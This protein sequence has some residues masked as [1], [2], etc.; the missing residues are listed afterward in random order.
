MP[1]FAPK[2][3]FSIEPGLFGA[4]AEAGA[5]PKK[6]KRMAKETK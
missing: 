5:E 6:R 1:G 2:G 3:P 4:K